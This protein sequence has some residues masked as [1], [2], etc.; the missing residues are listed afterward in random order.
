MTQM[1]EAAEK[2]SPH[3]LHLPDTRPAEQEAGME[4]WGT[5]WSCD[6]L[7][8]IVAL[9]FSLADLGILSVG[10]AEAWAFLIGATAPGTPAPADAPDTAEDALRLAARLRALALLMQAV[11]PS[12]TADPFVG[13]KTPALH[14]GRLASSAAPDT[15]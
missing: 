7:E 11:T 8:R 1:D 5:D 14:A 9:L 15:S 10:E 13:R 2:I 6:V 3:P 12:G 4:D